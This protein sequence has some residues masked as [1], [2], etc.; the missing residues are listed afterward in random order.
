MLKTISISFILAVLSIQAYAQERIA[1]QMTMEQKIAAGAPYHNERSEAIA[2]FK[3]AANIYSVGSKDLGVYLITT[4]DG[5][6]LI[7]TGVIEM[8]EQIKTNVKTLGFNVENIKIILSTHAHFDHVQGHE[9]MRKATGAE[10]MAVGLDAEALRLGK[11]IS[12][13]GFEGWE[14]VK[15]VKTLQHGNT[16]TLGATTLKAHQIPGHTQG[17]TVWET[18]VV[19]NNDEMNIALFGCRG[20]NGIVRVID[21]KDFPNLIDQTFLG[22][23]RLKDMT[24]TIY[25]SNHTATVYETFGESLRRGD[26]PHP[27]L[28]QKPWQEMVAELEEGFKSRLN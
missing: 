23:E 5:H 2:P 24:P 13:L 19:E 26:R 11:D 7:D 15:N 10:V 28:Q 18:T 27:L 1:D 4:D 20:P 12:P 14:P 9:A 16:V 22:F 25:L 17:C 6:I 3:V 21:N 8:H